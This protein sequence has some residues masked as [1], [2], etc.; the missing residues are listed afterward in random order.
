MAVRSIGA[1]QKKNKSGGEACGKLVSWTW[2]QIPT[3]RNASSFSFADKGGRPRISRR[4]FAV[5]F[6]AGLRLKRTERA[7]VY[8]RHVT[9]SRDFHG[10][11]ICPGIFNRRE[12]SE[13]RGAS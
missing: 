2:K 3:E 13:Y 12:S 7:T 11:M 4:S 8:M 9:L 6:L 1:F 5:A 10:L